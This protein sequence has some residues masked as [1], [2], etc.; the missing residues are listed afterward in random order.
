MSLI[1]AEV[2]LQCLPKVGLKDCNYSIWMLHV[3]CSKHIVHCVRKKTNLYF[4]V[5][6][7]VQQRNEGVV[8][9]IIC[10][11]LEISCAFQ[12]RKNAKIC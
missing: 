7:T 6:K 12:Q 11:L 3:F 10:T 4:R 9:S 1:T 5:P 8:K 2:E